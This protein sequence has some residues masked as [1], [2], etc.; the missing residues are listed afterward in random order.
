[1]TESMRFWIHPAGPEDI[2][3]LVDH[4]RNMFQEILVSRGVDSGIPDSEELDTAYRNKLKNELG[5]QCRAWI[6]KSSNNKIVA[7]GAVSVVSLVPV[8][9]DTSCKVGFLHSIFTESEYRNK[10][11]AGRIV[12]EIVRYCKDQGIKRVILNASS[13]GMPLYKKIGFESAE[14]SM[15]L[16]LG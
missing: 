16:W 15:R 8:P 4:H 12:E 6:M 5:H 14:N 11:F 2:P 10:G 1:M 3:V 9:N 13:D 7:S